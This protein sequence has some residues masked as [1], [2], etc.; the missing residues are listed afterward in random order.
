MVARNSAIHGPVLHQVG[1]VLPQRALLLRIRLNALFSG[2]EGDDEQHST[3]HTEESHGQLIALGAV[4]VAGPGD[5]R[6]RQ[7]LHDEP[8]G[9]GEDLPPGRDAGALVRVARDHAGQR[10]VGHVV[11]RV[12]EAQQGVRHVRVNDLAARAQVRSGEGE[13][14]DDGE[15]NRGPQQIRAEL[16]P[17]RV[18]AVRDG[19]HHRIEDRCDQA[20][21]QEQR[22]GL[23]RR[24]PERVGVETELQRQ[25]RLKDE[26]GG[27]V[28]EAVADL[29]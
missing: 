26:V 12:D 6:H 13:H 27:H 17:P 14:A 15:R 29:L 24:Q 1:E 7:A 11:H 25:H 16:A 9:I 8:R 18:G 5:H 21:H 23:R 22:P 10:R 2:C 3:K 4:A 28:A 19:A 20:H